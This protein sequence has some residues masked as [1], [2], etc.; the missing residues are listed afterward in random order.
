MKNILALLIALISFNASGQDKEPYL[1]IKWQENPPN[2]KAQW[3]A[4]KYAKTAG[5]AHKDKSLLTET[6]QAQFTIKLEWFNMKPGDII[7]IDLVAARNSQRSP[8]SQEMC[9]TY[10]KQDNTASLL[11][12]SAPIGLQLDIEWR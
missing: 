6:G 11:P 9:L 10:Q 12:L 8:V 3:Y 4:L 5:V 1:N 2:E 7:C